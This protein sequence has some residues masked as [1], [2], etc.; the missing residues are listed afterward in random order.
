MG[1]M[2]ARQSKSRFL[3]VFVCSSLL[4]CAGDG[5]PTSVAP[6]GV[7]SAT[8]SWT[9]PTRNDDGSPLADLAGYQ[10]LWGNT[11]NVYPNSVTIDNPGI[12]IYVIDNLAPGTYYFVTVA[13][14]ATGVESGF[15]NM[16]SKTIP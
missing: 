9:A 3:A 10:V 1:L 12:T 2:F 5:G 4:S 16:A 8:L 13:F 14:N 7:G 15:S 11:P 6:F